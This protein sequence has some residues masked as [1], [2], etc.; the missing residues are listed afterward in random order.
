MIVVDEL[1]PSEKVRVYDKG[2]TLTADPERI[3][4]LRIGYRSGDMWAPQLP[5]TEALLVAAEHFVDCIES[6]RKPD[7]DGAMGLRIVELLEA[8]TASL[9]RRGEPVEIKGRPS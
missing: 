9:R 6:G 5:T 8:A 4:Q 2:V 7:T 1:A 3:Y